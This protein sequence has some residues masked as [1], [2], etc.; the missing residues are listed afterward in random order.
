[1]NAVNRFGKNRYQRILIYV[2]TILCGL[3]IFSQGQTSKDV[4]KR[5]ADRV[6][7]VRSIKTGRLDIPDPT[8]L[9][10]SP[11]LNSFVIVNTQPPEKL[12]VKSK[13]NEFVAVSPFGEE[14]GKFETKFSID[15]PINITFDSHTNRLLILFTKAKRLIEIPLDNQIEFDPVTTMVTPTGRFRLDDPQGLA[16]DSKT[17]FIYILDRTGPQITRIERD[18]SRGLNRAVVSVISLESTGLSD[19]RGLSVDP[20]NGNLHI[21]S[22]TENR[23]YEVTSTGLI[24][25]NRRL[26]ELNVGQT[27]ST[28]FLLSA[29]V[30]DIPERTNELHGMTF[31]PTG[32]LT[33]S[34]ELMNLYIAT[35]DGGGQ[36]L[37]LSLNEPIQQESTSQGSL[38]QTIETSL[39]SPPSPDPAGITYSELADTLFISDSEVNEM[40]IFTGVNL[41]EITRAGVLVDTA[42]T[43]P[44]SFE[45]T[46][47][48]TNPIDGHFFVSDDDQKEVF[49]VDPGADGLFN[50]GDDVITSF[51]TKIY[52]DIDPE[53]ITF[54]DSEGVLFIA[55][56]INSEVYRVAPGN[57]GAFDGV[58][59]DG[60]DT[61]IHF[62]MKSLGVEDIEGITFDPDSG[63]LFVVGKPDDVLAQVTTSGLPV[64][65]IDIS[66]ADAD[67]PAGLT[68]APGSL[69]PSTMNI[70]IADRG[71]DND[72][73]SNENDG[74]VY[75]VSLPP[76]SPGNT[77]P[78]V[79]A[80]IDQTL[81]LPNAASLNGTVTDDGLPTGTL[82]IS[83]SQ[84]SGPG[85]VTFN[86]PS[87]ED[88]TATFS[89]AGIYTLRLTADDGE[90]I[91]S[92]ETTITVTGTNGEQI[93]EIPIIAGSD[94]AEQRSSGSLDLDSTDLEMVFDAGGNQTVGLRFNGV[95]IPQQSS[96]LNAYIQFKVDEATTAPTSLT[97]HAEA[98]DNAE[99]FI[100]VDDNLS[101][102]QFTTATAPWTPAPWPTP[103]A[104]TPA[105]RTPDIAPLIQEI[106]DRPGWSS[107]NSLCIIITGT[108]ERTAESFNGDQNGAPLLHVEYILSSGESPTVTISAPPNG[109][110]FTVGDFV[111]F[112]GNAND[113]EDGDI[114][115]NLQWE[116]DLDG[117]IGSGGSF[118]TSTL[119][120]GVHTITATVTD[121]D[122]LVG[123]DTTTITVT[124]TGGTQVVEIRVSASTDDAEE[125]LSGSLSIT[126]S[127][128]ELIFD[129]EGPGEQVVGMR[130]NQLTVP[131]QATIVDS[132]VQ[133]QVDETNSET[134]MLTIHG[135]R[136]GNATTFIDISNNITSRPLTVESVSWSPPPWT[137]R[138]AAGADQ[139]T[140]SLNTVIQEIVNLPGWSSG[141]S[142]C[143]I[144][145]GTGERTAESFNGDQNGAPLLHVEYTT[146]AGQPPTVTITAPPPGADFDHGE[147]ITF[148]GN[149]SDPEDGDV[150]ASLAWESNIDGVIGT[151][152]S[153]T[154]SSLSPGTHIVTAT[155]IDND[156]LTGMDSV[157]ITV[158]SS[159]EN[160]VGNPSFESG[161]NGWTAYSGASI[162]RVS[163]GIDGAFSLEISGPASTQKFG[164][165][166]S[167][168]W[169]ATT[170]AAGSHY[171]ITAWVRSNS[172]TGRAFLRVRE[173]LNRVKI[174]SIEST[175]EALSP[176]WKSVA[177]DYFTQGVGS[178]LDLQ[179][180]DDPVAP[181][182]IFE[183]DDISIRIVP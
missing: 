118:A 39:F 22:P 94:D 72:Y 115:A 7:P 53:G 138:G 23:L 93:V 5:G 103:G 63:H 48:T 153:F 150:T 144:I 12:A 181:G 24:V 29:D 30:G 175:S 18:A 67:K 1:M 55:D 21:C 148:T 34:P 16:V 170:P 35:A 119:S 99:T 125:R 8:G 152:G 95:P 56:G 91:A 126:S 9:G 147:P 171:Q 69:A 176:T 59:P 166:D 60:D 20:T 96:I 57:N 104:V 100:G 42:T 14:V 145:T 173:Y 113:P 47:I 15:N 49:E 172:S 27:Q 45:P 123:F 154:I 140:T 124:P 120:S 61:V 101:E 122:G 79:D 168:N 143:I 137:A 132:Y 80:G 36:I 85:T 70:Y 162:Q 135:E 129:D 159:S 73:D 108:G 178:T 86:N 160:L 87:S 41:F 179:I 161:T 84:I 89:M 77:P 6:K 75:E 88:T 141:N 68:L 46:G 180:L 43:T 112:T 10:F 169:V 33:D 26:P 114:T 134:T 116:S 28:N 182:E 149:G 163:G 177:V 2:I 62:D 156:G 127:D 131:A 174:G 136:T 164:V 32:D 50:T 111:N 19:L 110:T 139:R 106:V 40:A 38:I 121:N 151:G 109:A 52:G 90:L 97:V 4:G 133:F 128:L 167:P 25:A 142:L 44:F 81:S 64:R 31:A 71:V 107:G 76:I 11:M 157:S 158:N 82:L 13:L 65:M 165:N 17:G 102:R 78:D 83:W 155:A 130:F 146:G 74:K 3:A 66:A 98:V 54:D 37:E 183:A 92:D 51:D 105:Q 58:P 117:A